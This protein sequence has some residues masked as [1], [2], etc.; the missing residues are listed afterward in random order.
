MKTWRGTLRRGMP[1][2]GTWSLDADDGRRYQLVGRI[3]TTLE[4]R[5]VEVRGRSDGL[6]GIAV[7]DGVIE[8]EAIRR[9]GGTLGDP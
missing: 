8:V 3:P 9:L 1:G 6:M 5:R 7:L 2:L 4:G